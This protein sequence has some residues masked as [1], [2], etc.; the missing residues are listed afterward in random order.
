MTELVLAPR[1]S[2]TFSRTETYVKQQVCLSIF[3]YTQLPEWVRPKVV[4]TFPSNDENNL[5]VILSRTPHLLLWRGIW[6]M[7]NLLSDINLP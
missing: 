6:R 1:E 3:L 5:I 7:I 2:L 4:S